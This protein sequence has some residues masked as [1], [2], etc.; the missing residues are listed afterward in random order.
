MK[1]WC[2][3]TNHLAS[4]FWHVDRISWAHCYYSRIHVISLCMYER[5]CMRSLENV[6]Y[7]YGWVQATQ[8]HPTQ[9]NESHPS[10]YESD[11]EYTDNLV[12]GDRILPRDRSKP[13]SR[14]IDTSKY[15]PADTKRGASLPVLSVR[16]N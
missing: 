11:S 14:R 7:F 4:K 12:E 6:R 15:G 2:V 5:M 10:D 1:H 3:S 8:A 16:K 9:A 13:G